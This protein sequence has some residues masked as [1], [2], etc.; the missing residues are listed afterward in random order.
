MNAK[1]G[2]SASAR[3]PSGSRRFLLRL[4]IICLAALALRLAVSFELAADNG[5]VNSVMRPS[6][7]T[8]LATYLRLSEEISRGIFPKE[9][10]YQPFYYAVFLP[11]V[12]L[13]F[14]A[15]MPWGVLICQSLLGT[16]T[17][18]LV[19]LCG[20]RLRN[21]RTGLLASC[22]TAISTPL[23]LYTPFA[24]NETLHAF[25]L[26]LLFYLCVSALRKGG[27]PRWCAAGATAGA[28]ILNRGNVA[29]L[30]PIVAAAL[31]RNSLRRA[32]SSGGAWKDA[33]VRLAALLLPCVAVQLPFAVHNTLSRGTPTGPSTA[34]GA[35]LALGNTPEA[36]PG[37]RNPGL[38]AGPM[39][40]PETYA[41]FMTRSAVRSVP[42]QMWDFLLREPG[43]F[44][45][46]QFRKLLLFWDGREIPN[47][48]SLY[49]EGARSLVLRTLLPGRSAALLPFVLGGMFW[50][51]AA[52]LRRRR[53][54][55]L[56]LYGFVLVYWG[57]TA[58]FY[59]LSRFRAPILPL[60]FI[61]AGT[62]L[63]R[64]LR[65]LREGRRAELYR[66]AAPAL[67]A[68][69]FMVV[70]AYDLYRSRAES[71]IQSLVRP[72][73]V[74]FPLSSGKILRLDHGPFTFG[75]WNARALCS[76][77]SVRKTFPAMPERCDAELE[78]SFLVVRAPA[79]V[80]GDVN[81][82]P[83]RHVFGSPGMEKIRLRLP[84]SG[85][86]IR[87]SVAEVR[88]EL[89]L[90]CDGQRRYGRSGMPDPIDGEWI[91]RLYTER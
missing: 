85:G 69:V 58:L 29:L 54:S 14:G 50:Q 82:V 18:W 15:C 34:A 73:G 68:G 32:G 42:L 25:L 60:A 75:A 40:Y 10:Y 49:G 36:P 21:R 24:Q 47:N 48:V 51:L 87:F 88:G 43:A 3:R 20:A 23:L 30:L 63:E 64:A 2:R 89:A 77:A 33:A 45:E 12:R 28:A 83:L 8:D 4:S 16:A 11:P 9:F 38:P 37:G 57:A 74:I 31:F 6:R 79:S 86:E 27:A 46:L 72:D 19:G 59:I 66:R 35:V 53:D 7:L 80:A 84:V 61:F 44:A 5:G 90:L 17:V 76:G 65:L 26:T 67:L 78:I 56:M 39:E 70:P 71:L 52:V 1:P 22:A 41:D 81:G 55:W 62:F 91:M 13:F